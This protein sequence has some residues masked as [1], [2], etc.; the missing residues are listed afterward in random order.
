MNF[1]IRSKISKVTS[2]GRVCS[3]NSYYLKK[4]KE[5][6]KNTAILFESKAGADL[7]GNIF[8]L[9]KELTKTEYNKFQ[10][11]LSVN[12]ASKVRIQRLLKKYQLYN[13]LLIDMDSKKYLEILATAKYIVNDTSFPTWFYKRTEQVYLNTWHGTPLKR[14]GYEVENR[15]YAMGN[16]QKNFQVADYLLY[17]NDYMKEKMLNAY[18]LNNTYQ[19]KVLCEGY[20]RN[21]VFYQ[22]D[23]I[24]KVRKELK[25]TN[26]QVIVYM[27]TWR[28]T[29]T[30]T[31]NTEQIEACACNFALLDKLLKN[32]QVFYVK[33]HVFLQNSFDFTQYSH[34]KPFPKE[35]ETYD[36]L[37]A[38]DVLVTDYSSV[39]FDFANTR[40]KIIL[41]TYDRKDYLDER[42]LYIPINSLPFPQAENV[43]EL[44]EELNRP[45]EYD[46]ADFLRTY[47]TYDNMNAANR[48]AR[49][50]FLQQKVCK[51]EKARENGKQNILIYCSNLAKN[52]ITTSML[53]LIHLVDREKAN[54]FFFF[55]QN[56]FAKTPTRLSVVPPNTGIM[57][58][59]GSTIEWTWL[60]AVLHKLYFRLH[61]DS[62]FIQKHMN[63]LY[64]REYDKRF[65][66]VRIDKVV[67]FTGYAPDI[68]LYLQ[69]AKAPKVIFVHNDMYEE[70]KEKQNFD[71][72]ILKHAFES[73]N[74]IIAVSDA[75]RISIKKIGNFMD[76]VEVLQN[77]HNVDGIIEKANLPFIMEEETE[78]SVPYEEFTSMLEGD[79]MK[80]IT[81]GRFS[82]EKGHIKLMSAFNQ[83]HKK[84]PG[85]KLIIIGGYGVLHQKTVEYSKKLDCAKDI[86]IVK[87][88]SNPFTILKRCHLFLLPSDREP[89][90][91]VL[92]EA[93][94]LGIPIVATNIPGSGDFIREHKGY[95]V[96]N[97]ENGLLKGMNEFIEGKVKPLNISFTQYNQSIVNQFE[98]LISVNESEK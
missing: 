64:Q 29:L 90:G 72:N 49:H 22:N 63:S 77:A 68:T 45:K 58:L 53:N 32:N 27:P 24:Q 4:R 82:P 39:F 71:L 21:A 96:E 91:L 94:T 98:E 18:H 7:A 28:G 67:H 9:L 62:K 1:N 14:M 16:I 36:F 88:T 74:K 85:T 38:A 40:K 61:I 89:L 92:L 80:F 8:Y 20:P 43:T 35:Y 87:S 97:S 10:C 42:G 79:S 95:L 5:R 47:C 73:Y 65:H 3:R 76:K 17:P 81:I 23:R 34:I 52:G 93:D 19:G 46:E 33:F 84:H 60:E 13:I 50:V 69:Q 51:E 25:L 70:Y 78:L 15:A 55:K 12:M 37:N 57:P 66:N 48:I 31:N 30:E 26:Q 75:T 86:Y 6:I 41:F 83:F 56:Q 59:C 11:Y 44:N 54:Y 2:T